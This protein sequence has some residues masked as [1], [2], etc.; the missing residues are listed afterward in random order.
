MAHTI[1]FQYMGPNDDLPNAGYELPE[2]EF[3][4]PEGAHVPRVGE[5]INLI[6][7]K[8]AFD[9]VVLA[10]NTRIFAMGDAEPGWHSYIT[11]G[12]ASEVQDQRL[13]AIRE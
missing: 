8:G 5:F 1:S 13:V 7:D 3:K 2:G 9:L 6:I 11:V 12:P 10:V 4:I